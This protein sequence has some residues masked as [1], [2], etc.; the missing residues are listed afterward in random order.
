MQSEIVISGISGRFPESDD[1]AEFSRNLYQKKDL[2]TESKKRWEPET[3]WREAAELLHHYT[4]PAPGIM[5]WGDIGF[6]CQ[7]SSTHCRYTVPSQRN[8]LVVL[9]NMVLPYIQRFSN[10]IMHDLHVAR[11]VPEFFTYWIEWLP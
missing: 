1:V 7:P 5:V 2:V 4:G 3:P 10:R 8:I 9:E 11:N 6:H